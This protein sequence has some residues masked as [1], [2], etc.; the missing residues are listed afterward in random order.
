MVETRLQQIITLAALGEID[1]AIS[2]SKQRVADAPSDP[3]G[4]R[5]LSLAYL[6]ARDYENTAQVIR[7]GLELVPD[8]PALVERQ[9]D[10][11]AA[12]GRPKEALAAWRRAFTLA[13]EDYGISMRFSSAFLLEGLGRLAEAAEEW[14]FIIGWNHERGDTIHTDWPTRELQR[15]EAIQASA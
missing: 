2:R 12:T 11:Y 15:L 4:Y 9:G 5:V 1:D 3:D 14:R 7:A 10:L 13:P 6:H 8:D